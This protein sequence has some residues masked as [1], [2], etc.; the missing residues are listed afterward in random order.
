MW[1]INQQWNERQLHS[2]QKQ[3]ESSSR[4]E[5]PIRLTRSEFTQLMGHHT[6]QLSTSTATAKRSLIILIFTIK[7]LIIIPALFVP[8]G[9]VTYRRMR[10]TQGLGS[11]PTAVIFKGVL[12]CPSPVF[13]ATT[14]AGTLGLKL[15]RPESSHSVLWQKLSVREKLRLNGDHNKKTRHFSRPLEASQKLHSLESGCWQRC[16]QA[17]F[18]STSPAAPLQWINNLSISPWLNSKYSVLWSYK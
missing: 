13:H 9:L 17:S 11:S 14:L 15:N 18:Y 3:S 12:V 4:R 10:K 16:T 5:D 6:V 7:A 1:G 2:T 8:A